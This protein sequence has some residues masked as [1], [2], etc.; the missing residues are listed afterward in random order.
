MKRSFLFNSGLHRNTAT[1]WNIRHEA[2]DLASIIGIFPN[3]HVSTTPKDSQR[4]ISIY[5]GATNEEKTNS[6]QWIHHAKQ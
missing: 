4:S 1:V 2:K 6:H 5:D 3:L